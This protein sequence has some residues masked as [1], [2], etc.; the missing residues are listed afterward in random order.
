[1]SGTEIQR[2][3]DEVAALCVQRRHRPALREWR[4]VLGGGKE[5]SAKGS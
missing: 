4:A 2:Q 5:G 1:M 3:N